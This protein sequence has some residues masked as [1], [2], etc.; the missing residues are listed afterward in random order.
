MPGLSSARRHVISGQDLADDGGATGQSGAD[1]AAIGTHGPQNADED[2]GGVFLDEARAAHM[3]AGKTHGAT[4]TS[5][6][7]DGIV[8]DAVVEA[9]GEV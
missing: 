9:F 8:S 6:Q 4:G 1:P 2:V 5:G 3:D 7:H